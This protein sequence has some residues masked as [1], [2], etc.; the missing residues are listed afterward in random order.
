[1][2]RPAS[3]PSA[4]RAQ[5]V[6]EARLTARRGENLLAM[7]GIPVA[8]FALVAL[9]A[10]TTGA[11]EAALPRTMALA[12][13]A[14]G[15]VNL[16]IATAYERGYGVLKRLGGSP[17][18]RSGLVASKVIVVLAIGLL[19]VAGLGVIALV[20]G[21]R[22]EGVSLI[23]LIGTTLVGAAACAGIGLAIAGTL[24]AEA[25]L[26]VANIGFLVAIVLGGPL[27]S[28]V[29][30]P[31]GVEALSR[32]LPSGAL[33]EGFT[34][35]LGTTAALGQGASPPDLGRALLVLVAWGIAATGLAVRTFRWE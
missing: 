30:L 16:G 9:L 15:I 14:S 19:Q 7:V 2:S 33:A 20:L 18:G 10:P 8:A 27:A 32:L 28:V 24:R 12:I 34:V 25:A 17:L 29:A 23:A 1:M 6:V 5:T 35:A 21:W 4:V 11:L 22:P 31:D 3:W 26:V 13:V